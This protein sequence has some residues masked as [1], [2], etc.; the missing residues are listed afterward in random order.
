M[1]APPTELVQAWPAPCACFTTHT[2]L[3][4]CRTPGDTLPLCVAADQ[5]LRTILLALAQV[6]VE[7]RSTA[8]AEVFVEAGVALRPA[9]CAGVSLWR[10]CAVEAQRAGSHAHPDLLHPN[11]FQVHKE[12]WLA[13]QAAIVVGAGQTS[14]LLAPRAHTRDLFMLPVSG[15]A[16]LLTTSVIHAVQDDQNKGD[17]L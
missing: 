2:R 12:A 9:L 13:G 3:T 4:L 5:P 14:T 6:K 10:S 1:V 15:A 17:Q 7:P 11:S 8:C 16:V